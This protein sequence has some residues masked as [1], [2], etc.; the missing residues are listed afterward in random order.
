MEKKCYECEKVKPLCDFH[1]NPSM[2]DG[3]LNM[4]KMC[5]K[6]Y[7]SN[8]SKEHGKEYN[9]EYRKRYPNKYKAHIKVKSA[10]KSE[11]LIKKPCEVCEE[12]R[13][14]AHHDDYLN[15]LNVRWLCRQCHAD[16]HKENG[17]G[18]NA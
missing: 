6:S 7:M 1:K 8:H 14:D 18:K 17:H 5:H 2:K 9:R 3:R 10:I 4:C 13:V 12:E 16:W 15:Q 11:N